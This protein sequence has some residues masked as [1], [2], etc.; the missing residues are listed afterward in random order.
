MH[1][2]VWKSRLNVE[3]NTPCLRFDNSGGWFSFCLAMNES[4]SISP[5]FKWKSTFSK[6]ASTISYHWCLSICW[7]LLSPIPIT[8]IAPSSDCLLI[9]LLLTP[10]VFPYF[11]SARLLLHVQRN[12]LVNQAITARSNQTGRMSLFTSNNPSYILWRQGRKSNMTF[13]IEFNS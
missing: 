7:L 1:F 12:Y 4:Q 2:S 9:L 13:Q 11:F 10:H 6:A 8:T 5:E 3:H